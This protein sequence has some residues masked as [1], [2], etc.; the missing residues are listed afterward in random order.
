MM[1]E[2]NCVFLK[3]CFLMSITI[4]LSEYSVIEMD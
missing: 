1:K 3:K 2:R 4:C